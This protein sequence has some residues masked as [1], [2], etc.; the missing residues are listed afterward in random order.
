V[1]ETTIRYLG[2]LLSAYEVSGGQH[3]ALL[4]KA[5]ELGDKL[6]QAWLVVSVRMIVC[7]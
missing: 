5:Q 1:F 4:T 6:A 7:G 3:K 2:G